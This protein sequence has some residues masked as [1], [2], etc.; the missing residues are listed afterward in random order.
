MGVVRYCFRNLPKE[1]YSFEANPFNYE[2][3]RSVLHRGKI[4]NVELLNLAIGN[5]DG[6]IL[7]NTS[8]KWSDNAVASIT[9]IRGQRYDS[10]IEVRIRKLDSLGVVPDILVVDAEG[11]EL[12]ILEGGSACL[13]NLKGLIVETHSIGSIHTLPK[14][15]AWAKERFHYVRRVDEVSEAP[16][17]LAKRRRR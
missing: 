17:V 4:F 12:D 7:L 8:G 16:W 10:Q 13:E 3:A 9:G 11:S 15:E 14:V 2:V 6:R 5:A 1:F